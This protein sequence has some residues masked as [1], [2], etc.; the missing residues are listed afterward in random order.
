[1]I[2]YY[3]DWCHM[4]VPNDHPNYH[5]SLPTF[6][7][8]DGCFYP[9]TWEY[10]QYFLCKNCLKDIWQSCEAIKSSRYVHERY[11]R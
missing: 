8:Q 9:D 6:K 11:G 1:M 4:E 3:C 7:T 5:V 10:K 2:K